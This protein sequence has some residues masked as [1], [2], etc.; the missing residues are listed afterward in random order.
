ADPADSCRGPWVVLPTNRGEVR[1]FVPKISDFGLAKHLEAG[2][3]LTRT[4]NIMG[5]PAYMAPEQ[6]GLSPRSVGPATDVYALG[7]ILYELLT[8]QPPFLAN[9]TGD[10]LQMQKDDAPP[11]SALRPGVDPA[12]D[13]IVLR[14]LE[15]SPADRYASA[16]ALADDLEA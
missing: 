10:T 13:A 9:S 1:C 16:G 11:P 14:C 12:L 8:S 2:D 7:A 3:F 4:G 6:H 5:T 15:R